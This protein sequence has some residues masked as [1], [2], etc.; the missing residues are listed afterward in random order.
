MRVGTPFSREPRWLRTLRYGVAVVICVFLVTLWT[1]SLFGRF[2]IC[3]DVLAHVGP[4]PVVRICGPLSLGDLG[5]GW[6]AVILLL[7]EVS[8]VVVAGMFSLKGGRN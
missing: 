8:E 4:R 3:R 2:H 1:A 5:T 7:P 6:V